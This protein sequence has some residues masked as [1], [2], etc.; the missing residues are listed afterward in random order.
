VTITKNREENN[1]WA[2]P[3]PVLA[4]TSSFRLGES[5]SNGTVGLSHF[6]A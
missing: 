4:Q 3:C 2:R 1:T 6:L 5:S